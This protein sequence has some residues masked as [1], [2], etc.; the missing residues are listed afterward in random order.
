MRPIAGV[1]PGRAALIGLGPHLD[2]R[3]APLPSAAVDWSLFHVLNGALRHQDG[4]QDAAQVFNAWALFVLVAVAGVLWFVARPGGSL[5]PKQAAV[6]AALAAVLALLANAVLGRLWFHDRPFVDHPHATVLLVRHGADNSFPSDHASVA[7]AVAFAVAGFYRR[8]GLMLVLGAAAVAIDRIFVGVHYPV[9]VASSL[10][11][12]LGA[13]GLVTT[14]GR[15]LVERLVRLL[16]R[17][18]DPFVGAIW[19]LVTP[20]RDP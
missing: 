11:V 3:S 15:G 7:F 12:G 14:V 19:E 16:S 1:A 9:D 10:L 6:S 5:R 8:Y 18:S 17:I 13:A 4:G 20:A 2:P